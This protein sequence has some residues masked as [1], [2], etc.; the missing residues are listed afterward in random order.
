MFS[1]LNETQSCGGFQ[2]YHFEKSFWKFSFLMVY[3][4]LFHVMWIELRL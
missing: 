4:F 2:I 1:N 3:T